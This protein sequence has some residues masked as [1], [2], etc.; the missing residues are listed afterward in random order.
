MLC[1]QGLLIMLRYHCPQFPPDGPL[2]QIERAVRRQS[3]FF[4]RGN[5]NRAALVK[6]D[7]TTLT[8]MRL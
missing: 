7:T 1:E 2:F 3:A 4:P 5:R 6:D 8:A